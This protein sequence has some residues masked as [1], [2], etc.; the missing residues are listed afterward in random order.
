MKRCKYEKRCFCSFSISTFTINSFF[1]LRTIFCTIILLFTDEILNAAESVVAEVISEG[2]ASDEPEKPD[3]VAFT[4]IMNGVD[5][6]KVPTPV[7]EVESPSASPSIELEIRSK[8]G[9]IDSNN[10]EPG[11]SYFIDT[12]KIN[13]N[14]IF[15]TQ[16]VRKCSSECLGTIYVLSFL[17]HCE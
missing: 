2:N 16:F 13:L 15:W 10:S 7:E 5:A 14:E 4:A 9:D 3:P 17:N 6:N 8:D 1:I 12:F 11:W